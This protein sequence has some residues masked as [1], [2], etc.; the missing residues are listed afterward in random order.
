MSIHV[1]PLKLPLSNDPEDCIGKIRLR[2]YQAQ[3]RRC[4]HSRILLKAPTGSGKTLGCL[5]R[6]IEDRGE[7]PRFGTTVI[8]YPTN[9][10]IWD[11]ARSLSEL[12]GKLGK[13]VNI[14]VESK[15]DITWDK[16]SK[17]ADVNLYVLNGE[18]LAALAQQAKSS[19]GKSLVEQ[20]RRDQA[21]NRII[22]SNPEILYY[23][24]LYKFARNEEL[25][26][27]IFNRNPPN[28]L[29]FDEFHL[30]HG[31]TLATITYM[32][33]YMKNYFDQIIFSSATPIAVESI[34]HENIQRIIAEP[35][36]QGDIVKHQMDLNL[37]STVG[38]LGSEEIP[39]IKNMV[40]SFLEKN[41]NMPQAV[42]VL[43][44]VNSVITCAKIIEALEEDYPNQV[45]AIHGL[46]PSS[47]RPRN[48]SE[49]K[50][51]VVGTSAIE[52]GIDFDTSSLIFEAHDS[53]SFLQRIGRGARHSRCEA[54]AFIPALY[55][56]SFS[57]A[58]SNGI[59]I[60]PSRLETDAQSCLPDL[61]SYSAFPSNPQ[62]APIMVA[63]LL[64]WT[65][66]RPAG[67]RRLN[68][69]QIITE[70]K[71]QLER[72]DFEV[73][74]EIGFSKEELLELCEK[75]PKYGILKIAQK[76]S[77]R[78]SMDS[79]P[80]VFKSKG[81]I[82]VQFD[83]LSLN[84]LPRVHFNVIKRDELKKEEIRIPW[85][86]KLVEEFI[87]VNGIRQ[88]YEKVRLSFE[89]GRFEKAPEPLTHFSVVADD[90]NIEERLK[91]IL[92]A[93]PAYLLFSKEDWRLPGFFTSNGDFLA[94]GGDAYLAWFLSN[95]HS[96]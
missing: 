55:F 92:E 3:L 33:A 87:Q 17:N 86:M 84:E 41:K 40:S 83:Y 63:I 88:G 90:H 93:Q 94:V 28:L 91:Q 8:I 44:I 96:V 39:K 22:L 80:A 13:K 77:C 30:Y 54:T 5:V 9:S 18:T 6:A 16:E 24:F 79:I 38:I 68:Y 78:S 67:G 23:L 95:L 45:T 7:K 19:E 60:K 14:T 42:K 26:D 12:I 31:Y 59:A 1:E 62:A 74:K 58:L 76:M 46:I 57:K 72:G 20:L 82:P 48:S 35:S 61:P 21:S 34:I 50:P 75:A 29:I 43:L 65:M 11:Q 73:P 52:V 71:L 47:S 53:S 32:L 51:I 56:S 69:G 49:F 2:L 36:E 66:Q 37:E 25:I 10:L 89:P 81:E 4:D 70:T 27:S 15:A 64:N 85:R